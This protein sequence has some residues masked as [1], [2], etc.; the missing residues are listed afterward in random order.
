MSLLLLSLALLDHDDVGLVG[1]R[2]VDGP[3]DAPGGL[4]VDRVRGRGVRGIS[5]VG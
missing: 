1:E 4:R 3:I 5:R 2:L